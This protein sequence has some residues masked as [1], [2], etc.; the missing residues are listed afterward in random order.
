MRAVSVSET[1]VREALQAVDTPTLERIGDETGLSRATLFRY[2]A[3]AT[4][5][6]SKL[7]PLGK[8]LGLLPLRTAEN[9][10]DG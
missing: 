2:R 1:E 3:G 5:R 7:R 6:G 10:R 9:G 8:A 4:I